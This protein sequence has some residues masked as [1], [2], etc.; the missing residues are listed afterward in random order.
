MDIPAQGAVVRTER[1]VLEPLQPGDAPE[2]V[3]VL[4]DGELH[5]FIGGQPATLDELRARYVWL[6]AGSPDPGEVWVNWIIRQAGDQSAVGYVQA[7]MHRSDGGSSAEI[8]W[9]VGLPW[10]GRGFATEAAGALLGWLRAQGVDDVVAHVHPDHE[11]SKAVAAR[12][13][14]RP[15]AEMLD[16]EVAWRTG[17]GQEGPS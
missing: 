14:L 15:T 6:A 4:G 2:M 10:Q 13:G 1:L 11:A 16:G 3:V 17:G 9:V 5:E 12:I 8:A 7:T